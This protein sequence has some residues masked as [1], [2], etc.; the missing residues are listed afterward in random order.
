MKNNT[1]F[2]V[3]GFYQAL[4]ATRQS[5]KI[6]W[7]V[8]AHE[9]GISPSTL[10]RMAQLKRPDV[11]SLAKLTVWSGLK[12]DDFVRSDKARSEVEPIAMISTLLSRL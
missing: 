12:T 7:R 9:A 4:D 6:S 2:D 3:E 8:V 5:R 11:D 10:T 1:G